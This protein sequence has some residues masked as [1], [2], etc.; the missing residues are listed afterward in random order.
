MKLLYIC[1]C[2]DDVVDEVE[3]PARPAASPP[4]GLTG[5]GRGDIIKADDG[6]VV[7]LTTLC[8]DCRE[9]LYGE[10]G[11]TIIGGPPLH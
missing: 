11:H 7:V 1:E 10:P 8:S 3:F 4:G 9:L 6:E 5:L 2:C